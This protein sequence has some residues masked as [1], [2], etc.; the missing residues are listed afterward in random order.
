MKK[1]KETP[2]ILEL[3]TDIYIFLIIIIFPLIVDKTGFFKILECKWKSYVIITSIYIISVILINLYYL[4][5]HKIK[6][7]SHKLTTPSKIAILFLV[8]NILSF[9]FSPYLKTH[10]LWLGTGRGEGLIVS[11]L[12]IISFILVSHFAKFDKKHI[13]YFSISSI[14][15]SSIAILQF[16]GFNPFNMYQ[17]GIGTHNVSFMTTI[18][19]VDFIS[20]YYTM[21]LTISAAS[22]LFLD[23]EKKEKLIHY[24]SLLFGSFIFNII[25]VDSGKVAFLAV[26]L[27]MMPYAFQNNERLS[28]SLKI[29]ATILLSIA[30]NMFINVEYHYDLGKLGFYF[31]IDY[32]LILFIII[33]SILYILS[34]YIKKIPYKIDNKNYIKNY[35]KLGFILGFLG[36]VALFIIPFKSGMLYEIHEL[37]HLNFDDNFGTYRIFLWKRTIPLIKEYPLLGSGPDTFALRFMPKYSADIAKIGPLTI[38]DT[39]ANIYLTML[40]N[41]GIIG[42]LIYLA[43]L[44]IQVYNGIK[45]RNSYS[46]VLLMGIICYMVSSF[47]NLSV[48]VV[49]PLF[50][51]L[52]AIHD[53][54]LK[55]NNIFGRSKNEKN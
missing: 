46:Y 51:I 49:S 10:N 31:K 33:I 40:V 50:W 26:F 54:C 44:I 22:L 15:V 11:S 4:I 47:F 9:L 24:I 21:M 30:I 29:I 20:A 16:I 37:L 36:I 43:F 23:N 38:N 28:T 18:G 34:N 7:Y 12:Y 52:M 39:A 14:L 42:T 2:K 45:N 48:V 35:Y 5:Y 8:S 25:E 55:Q 53:I 17:D 6:L 32:I 19:N 27:V 13:L 3:V 41:L 1:K